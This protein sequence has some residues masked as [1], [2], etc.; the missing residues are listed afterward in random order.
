MKAAVSYKVIKVLRNDNVNQKAIYKLITTKNVCYKIT[1][2][3][4]TSIPTAVAESFS[5]LEP[6]TEFIPKYKTD[7]S[8]NKLRPSNNKITQV[9]I[10]DELFVN[11]RTDKKSSKVTFSL[12][13]RFVKLVSRFNCW[14]LKI[15]LTY[16][17]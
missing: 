15:K 8:S 11:D 5:S 1:T 4:F 6:T 9:K 12:N 2:R 10:G 14:F 3:G 16:Y 7:D 13:S 17:K